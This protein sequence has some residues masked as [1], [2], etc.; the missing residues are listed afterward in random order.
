MSDRINQAVDRLASALYELSYRGRTS[1]KPAIRMLLCPGDPK[2]EDVRHLHGIGLSPELAE[3]LADTIEQLLITLDTAGEPVDPAGADDFA[4][5]NPEL[6]KDVASAFTGLDLTEVTRQVL[7]DT[8][9]RDRMTVTRAL[10]AM[11]GDT[12][13]QQEDGDDA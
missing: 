4:R 3:L 9:P 11:F 2:P 7:N 8:D 5:T 10:D 6:A 12:Q 13:D 1:I